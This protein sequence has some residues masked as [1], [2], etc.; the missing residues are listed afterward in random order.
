MA[1]PL[2]NITVKASGLAVVTLSRASKMNALSLPMLQAVEGAARSPLLRDPAVR[3]VLLHGDG[4]AFCAGLD[5]PAMAREGRSALRTVLDRSPDRLDN[6]AQAV[7]YQ[8]RALPVPVL[9]ATHGVCFG[10]GL[11][12]ALGA[13]A[14]F[15]T[16]DCRFSVMEAKWGLIPDMS[17]SVTLRE[18]CG[19]STAKQ[20]S[21]TAEIFDG[22]RAADLGLVTEVCAD[23]VAR[24]E[25]YFEGLGLAS[26]EGAAECKQGLLAGRRDR[27]YG[28]SSSE[29]CASGGGN[30][31]ARP[32][33]PLPADPTLAASEGSHAAADAQP[34]SE[35]ACRCELQEAGGGVVHL[36]LNGAGGGVVKV[37]WRDEDPVTGG[38]RYAY[39]TGTLRQACAKLAANASVRALVVSWWE[40][41]ELLKQGLEPALLRQ[42]DGD[43]AAAASTADL[44]RD[45]PMPVLAVLG[46]G[47][48]SPARTLVCLGADMRVASPAARFSPLPAGVVAAPAGG[49]GGAGAL[50]PAAIRLREL[51]GAALVEA[52]ASTGEGAAA[53]GLVDDVPGA[54]AGSLG[55]WEDPL[56]A[57]VAA[58]QE[59]AAKSPDAAVAAKALYNSTWHADEPCSLVEETRLQN[60]LILAYN[61]L[62]KTSA[63]FMPK[64][65]PKL[66]FK[67]RRVR[68]PLSAAAAAQAKL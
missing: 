26:A 5:V 59:I 47:D 55:D 17:A 24:A 4:R 41:E 3:G 13:D 39:E 31:G 36:K 32:R 15:T 34:I 9:A 22:A 60:E 37:V 38:P 8:W 40:E 45:L 61:M 1:T 21:W 64:W 18:V 52:M 19:I 50:S 65:M 67:P 29:I 20:L 7:G 23:P 42:T 27:F 57:A 63:N 10:G 49:S 53:L 43:M 28:Y 62:A 30:G 12:I 66:P 46:A 54:S 16:P 44:L 48:V 14:R 58:A 35:P 2:V 51:G 25:E 56:A 11:Q 68:G 6:L 33:S